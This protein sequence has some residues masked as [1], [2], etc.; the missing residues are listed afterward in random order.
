MKSNLLN[1]WEIS[2]KWEKLEELRK[3]VKDNKKAMEYYEILKELNQHD[4]LY[5]WMFGNDDILS[6]TLEDLELFQNAYIRD[7]LQVYI[8][9]LETILL[10]VNNL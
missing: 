7:I 6:E 10:K 9:E 5:G 1:D 4:C 2:Q 8:N 3:Q